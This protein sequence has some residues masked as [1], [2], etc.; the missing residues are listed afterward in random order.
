MALGS[1]EVNIGAY[2]VRAYESDIFLAGIGGLR[3]TGRG[4]IE[5]PQ[6]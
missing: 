4:E 2:N 1:A 3:Y 6:S 5:T